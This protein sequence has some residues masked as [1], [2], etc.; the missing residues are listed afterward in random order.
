VLDPTDVMESLLIM[1]GE[2]KI[3]F[4]VLN[5][6]IL[7]EV[8]S[9]MSTWGLTFLEEELLEVFSK[10]KMPLLFYSFQFILFFVSGGGF[11]THKVEAT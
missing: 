7:L 1:D 6:H 11:N 3:F 10:K 2:K 4:R 8:E 9:M 5:L